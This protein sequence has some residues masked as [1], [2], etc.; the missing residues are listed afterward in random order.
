MKSMRWLRA[1]AIASSVA[2]ILYASATD[3]RP[4]LILHSILLPVDLY[5][6]AQIELDRWGKARAERRPIAE[7]F[8]ASGR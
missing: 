6:L 4:I 2:F 5:R 1:T 7:S 3:M 8:G